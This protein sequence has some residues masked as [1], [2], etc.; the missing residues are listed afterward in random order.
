VFFDTVKFK[1]GPNRVRA[2][3]FND[4][5]E[6]VFYEQEIF[7]EKKDKKR[8]PFPLWVEEKSVIPAVDME[9]TPDDVVHVKFS[10]SKGQEAMVEVIPGSYQFSC[11]RKDHDDYSTYQTE[12]PL[13]KFVKNKVLKLM[14]RLNDSTIFPL[15]KTVTVKEAGDF[16]Y[17]QT[18]A[19]HV[20]LTYNRGPVRL[21][22]PIRSEYDKGI[23][24]RSNG[25]IGKNYRIRLNE[26]ETG[27]IAANQVEE[28]SSEF[29]QQPYYITNLFSAPEETADV[30]NIPYL[31]PIP[32]EVIPEPDQNRIVVRLFGAKTSSTWITHRRGL[33]VIE[34][35]SWQQ[36]APETYEVYIHLKTPKIWG[37]EVYP[38]GTNLSIKLKHPPKMN[39]E[40]EKPLAGLRMAIEAG[41]GG[42]NTGAQGLSGLLEKD[43]NLD[44]SLK[45]GE[46]CKAAGA[47]VIQI[48]PSDRDMSLLAKR[49]TAILSNADLLISIHANAAGGGFLRVSGTSTYYH[50]AFWAPLAEKIYGRLLEADLKEFG[51][52]G[53][54][55]YTVIRTSQLPAILVEQAFMTHAEDEEKLANPAFRQQMAAKIYAGIIDYLAYMSE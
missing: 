53:S 21:G 6:E 16:P 12:L 7:Y 28:L 36:T 11:L 49:D 5:G 29:S 20:R 3:V 55:N 4:A 8:S 34:K 42:S 32:Y 44:L 54:F 30:V 43:I 52:V 2:S 45:L 41:H 47:E 51:L 27:I 26:I 48:R 40:K 50:N 1:E 37:Y 15:E 46:I 31:N 22:G 18:T 38:N 24:L 33:K 23:I 17:V 13:H 19:D 25:K 39:V 14:V 9:L 10:G 35:V